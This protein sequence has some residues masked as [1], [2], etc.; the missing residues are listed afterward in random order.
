MDNIKNAPEPLHSYLI[1]LES[2]L[3]RSPKTVDEY[4]YSIRTFYRFL[5]IHFGLTENVEFEHPVSY[6]HLDVY[7]RQ[8]ITLTLK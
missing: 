4:F 1:Y 7:K 3:G 8:D 6:T 5:N 2:I